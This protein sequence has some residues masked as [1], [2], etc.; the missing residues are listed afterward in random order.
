MSK[1]QWHSC[2]HS[3]E[4][5]LFHGWIIF[6]HMGIPQFLSI[7]KRTDISSTFGCYESHCLNVGAHLIFRMQMPGVIYLTWLS[8]GWNDTIHINCLAQS[9]THEKVPLRTPFTNG[10]VTI[11]SLLLMMICGQAF[12]REMSQ[13]GRLT[14]KAMGAFFF[15]HINTIST[16]KVM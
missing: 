14:G 16:I 5:I 12:D 4:P 2:Y 11:E 7:C 3:D 1:G 6:H 8:R 15:H 10:S 13:K 9:L